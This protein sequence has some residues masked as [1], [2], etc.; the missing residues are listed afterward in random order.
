MFH[1]PSTTGLHRD[2]TASTSREREVGGRKDM[3]WNYKY[4]ERSQYKNVNFIIILCEI[5]WGSYLF[6]RKVKICNL[7]SGEKSSSVSQCLTVING[8][9]C[10]PRSWLVSVHPMLL[11]QSEALKNSLCVWLPRAKLRAQCKESVLPY[12]LPALCVVL[13]PS[14]GHRKDKNNADKKKS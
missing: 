13:L 14:A 10:P 1:T 7:T 4:R 11:R 3:K 5:L 2:C 6:R 8:Y 9:W 12:Y